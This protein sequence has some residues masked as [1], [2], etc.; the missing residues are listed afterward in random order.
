[1]TINGLSVM[2]MNSAEEIPKN[3][4][5]R[6]IVIFSPFA[7]LKIGLRKKASLSKASSLSAPTLLSW[8]VPTFSGCGLVAATFQSA[9]LN[10][11]VLA[12]HIGITF[13]RKFKNWDAKKERGG[14]IEASRSPTV[15]CDHHPLPEVLNLH[16]SPF[17]L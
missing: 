8:R 14:W 13:E 1:M 2:R 16:S 6:I 10:L 5:C 4:L 7:F 3:A 12:Y 9:C 17:A 15:T 11:L